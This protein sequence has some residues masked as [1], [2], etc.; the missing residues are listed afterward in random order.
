MYN[1]VQYQG[2]WLVFKG[3]ALLDP[4]SVTICTCRHREHAE[5][6]AGVLNAVE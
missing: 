1:F 3:Q 4:N 5:L 6:V 2:E